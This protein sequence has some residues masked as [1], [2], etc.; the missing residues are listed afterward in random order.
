M[1]ILV[2]F[3]G[4]GNYQRVAYALDQRRLETVYFSRAAAGFFGAKRVIV[5]ATEE[6]RERH[7][8]ALQAA[9]A[10]LPK[11][12]LAFR[13]IPGGRD[14][15]ELWRIFETLAET[16]RAGE[17]G[18]NRVVL[19]ITHG[20]RTLPFFAAS[21]V[22]YLRGAGLLPADFRVVYGAFEARDAQGVAPVWEL[23]AFLDLLDWAHGVSVFTTT[24]LADPLLTT[25]R[26]QDGGQRRAMARE[27]ERRFPRT[28]K[29]AGALERF[30]NDF[31]TLRIAALV[32]GDGQGGR[33]SAAQLLDAIA[34]YG[35][36]AGAF[37]PAL[38]PLL[39]R[40][41]HRA[42]GIE[43]PSLHGP[44]ADRALRTL[45]RRYLEQARYAGAAVVVREAWVSRYT[46]APEQAAAGHENFDEAGRREA[47]QRWNRECA[48]ARTVADVRNDIEHGGFRRRP[49][50]AAA[51]RERVKGL[52]ETLE[53]TAAEAI[54]AGASATG[55]TW[56]VSRHPGAV[57][58][59]RRQ[60]I[61]VDE[62]VE[63]LDPERVEAGDRVIGTLPVHLAA[64]ICERRAE[65]LH[66]SLD[67]P[68]EKRGQ[69]LS[70]DELDA[71][72]ARLE[73]FSVR[74]G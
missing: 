23:T 48:E 2:S 33:S 19:D 21:A 50:P 11:V 30:A 8:T 51:L 55:R 38:G 7:G 56:F 57:D 42:R 32:C 26:A 40:I 4:T 34:D 35:K 45:A 63:H 31:L 67:L 29:L 47:E 69:E 58:W 68:P 15:G 62:Q 46:M 71:A 24:G 60:D 10:D 12:S 65:Y 54:T 25:F 13:E 36:E 5:L 22:A 44:E 70:A 27:G 20:F 59:A 64:R 49:L 74:R 72:G 73:A 41:T 43:A 53:Q 39:E 3:L 9:F 28:N 6:A 37:L 52:V 17:E 16:L 18:E 1:T 14:T 66:L 61:V